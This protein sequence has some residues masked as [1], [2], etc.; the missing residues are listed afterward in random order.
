M[1]AIAVQ[2]V[3]PIV[4]PIVE[5]NN[6]KSTLI[7]E[8]LVIRDY[9]IETRAEDNVDGGII[10]LPMSGLMNSQLDRHGGSD[11]A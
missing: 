4:L 3:E 2:A 11:S 10:K 1:Y 9:L 5:L 8:A 7:K 6:K